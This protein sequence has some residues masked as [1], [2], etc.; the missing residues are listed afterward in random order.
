MNTILE[1]IKNFAAAAHEGQKRKYVDEPY[2]NHPIRVSEYCQGFSKDLSIAAAAIL[3]D[4]LEDTAVTPQEMNSFLMS[5][6]SDG[7]A[8]H[9]MRLVKDLTDVYTHSAYPEMN[10]RWR[11]EK[12]CDRLCK[13]HPDAQT[14]KYADIIDNCN[15]IA[16]SGDDFAAAYLNECKKLLQRITKGNAGMYKEA[17]HT[18]EAG[19]KKVAKE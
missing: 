5:I 14:I 3:H 17:I 15:D 8:R 7:E 11:K 16:G 12:E 4:V 6:M 13:I 10:R 19:L 1:K 18:V 9:T 2:V